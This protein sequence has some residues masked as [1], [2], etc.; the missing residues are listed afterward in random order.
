MVGLSAAFGPNDTGA[1]ERTQIYGMDVYWKWKPANAHAGFPFVSWQTEAIF[2]RFEAAANLTN[3]PSEL[4]SL[5]AE[6]LKDWGF[7][8][9]VLWGF[10]ERWVAG[11]RGEYAN[12]NPGAYDPCDVFRNERMRVSPVSDVLP[13]RVLQDSAA[14]STTTTASCSAPSIRSGCNSSSCWARMGR[15]SFRGELYE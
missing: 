6:T 8:S 1:H 2:Q 14:V 4:T 7:Y 13:E 9:Q 15:T 11:L 10:K 5:P 12:G 3:P